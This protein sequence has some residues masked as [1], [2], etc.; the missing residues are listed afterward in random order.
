MCLEQRL[1]ELDDNILATS[2]PIEIVYLQNPHRARPVRVAARNWVEYTRWR[3]GFH[4]IVPSFADHLRISIPK[5]ALFHQPFMTT[6]QPPK[7]RR[8]VIIQRALPS[9]RVS[10]FERLRDDLSRRG[11]ELCLV[12]GQFGDPRVAKANTMT[13]PWAKTV[14]TTTFSAFGRDVWWQPALKYV[15][16]ADLVI[17][18]QA[19]RH[20]INHLLLLGRGLA[21]FKVAFWGHGRDFQ[22]D[23]PEGVLERLKSFY[24]RK[25]DWWFAYTESSKRA[26]LES[27][28]PASRIT[29]VQNSTDTDVLHR[30]LQGVTSRALSQL[31]TKLGVTSDHIAVYCGGLYAHKRIDFLLDAATRVRTALPDFELLVMGAGP[32]KEKLEE[33][34][35]RLPWLHILG[36]KLGAERVLPMKLATVQL[37]PGL[38]GLGI[39]DSFVLEVP[40]ITTDIPIHSPE[41]SYLENGINGLTTPNDVA[42]YAAEVVRVMADKA[43]LTRLRA[44]CKRAARRYTVEAMVDNFASGVCECLGIN[45]RS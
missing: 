29:V 33:A 39:V 10:F 18:E 21:G 38:V 44:G 35:K 23:S 14:R 28:M 17:C 4:A 26:V 13:L 40:M 34:A 31:R 11:V 32:E 30:A 9:F 6:A 16:G 43:T 36:P 5:R 7:T 3:L 15:R 25:A 27:G 45:G 12:H 8:V 19:N 22:T 37:M 24:T 20:L 2:D 1:L 41:I 42:Q